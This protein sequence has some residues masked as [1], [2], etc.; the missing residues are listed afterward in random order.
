M[1]ELMTSQENQTVETPKIE[2]EN[3]PKPQ[4]PSSSCRKRVNDDNATFFENLKDHMGE[5]F[6]ASM[7]EH[8]TCFKNTMDKIFG[9]S[10]AVAE[11]QAVAK[12]AVE[13]HAPLQ[14]AA[15]TK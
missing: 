11:K 13:I 4:V 6:N 9:K 15:V 10:D 3:P 5:F 2:T 7:E 8:K 12:E 14:A 1:V